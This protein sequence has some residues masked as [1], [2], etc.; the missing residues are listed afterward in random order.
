MATPTDPSGKQPLAP[1]VADALL[2]R[3]STDDDFRE[4]F[5]SDPTSAL[6]ELGHEASGESL[7]QVTALASKEAFAEASEEI[8]ANLTA[9]AAFS[10]PHCFESGTIDPNLSSE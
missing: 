9:N 1:E 8:K 4:R 3:L 5:A 6:A 10:D 2:R 7:C